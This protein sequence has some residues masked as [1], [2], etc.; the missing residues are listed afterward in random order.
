MKSYLEI[1]SFYPKASGLRT[2]F[3]DQFA[4][5]RSLNPK[6]FVW[7]Y[8][9]VPQQYAHLRTPAYHY[10]PKTMYQH[11][12][13]YLVH[14]TRREL[15]CWDIS[16]PWL[17]YYVDGCFQN[18]HSDHPHGPWAYVFSLTVNPKNFQGGETFIFRKEALS[19][20][21]SSQQNYFEDSHFLKKLSPRFNKLILFDP[22]IP[23]GVTPVS[24]VSDPL[25][26]RLV[27]HGWLS[28]PKTFVDGFLPAK[29]VERNLNKAFQKVEAL[30]SSGPALQGVCS[31]SLHVATTGKIKKAQ[32]KTC[33]VLDSSGEIPKRFLK[34]VLKF[35]SE[36]QFPV[37]RGNSQITIPL[38]FS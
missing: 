32:F 1:N 38:L 2:F 8:W 28:H 19:Y 25:K 36:L 11:F 5:P 18:V 7:D 16:P 33:S 35:Y 6:R 10:F 21:K 29:L 23:H 4:D 27:I 24:G 37:A 15:G 22:R 9:H 17:S 12:H 31:L 34:Q 3:E 13:S 20:W 14:W 30:S 26:A